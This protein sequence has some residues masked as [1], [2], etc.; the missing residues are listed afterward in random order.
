[1]FNHC[2]DLKNLYFD[3]LIINK[4]TKIDHMFYYDF[5]KIRKKL[6]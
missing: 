1:M 6:K 2:R 4:T 3:N 5:E